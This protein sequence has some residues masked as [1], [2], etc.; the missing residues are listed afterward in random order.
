MRGRRVRES[1]DPK[2]LTSEHNCSS[3]RVQ[4][5]MACFEMS[6][7]CEPSGD[8][9]TYLTEGH[10]TSAMALRCEMSK[11]DM[12]SSERQSIAPVPA[13][14]RQSVDGCGGAHFLVTSFWKFLMRIWWFLSSTAKRCRATNTAERPRPRLHSCEPGSAERPSR[15]TWYSSYEPAE[16]QPG[17]GGDVHVYVVG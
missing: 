12:R 9:T 8:Q 13:G 1:F 6:A 3:F 5:A 10:E 16:A 17:R 4:M 11:S 7:T 2:P 14:K 15:G